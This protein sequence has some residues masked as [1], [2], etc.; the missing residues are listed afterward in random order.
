MANGRPA[1]RCAPRCSPLI[2]RGSRGAVSILANAGQTGSI[3]FRL[4]CGR[5]LAP[6]VRSFNGRSIV[7]MN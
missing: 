6:Q 3:G 5:W 2:K 7:G 4:A 1:G